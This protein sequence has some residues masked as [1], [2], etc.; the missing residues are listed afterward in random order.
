MWI[1]KVICGVEVIRMIMI[2]MVYLYDSNLAD[3]AAVKI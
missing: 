1:E 3:V 2:D